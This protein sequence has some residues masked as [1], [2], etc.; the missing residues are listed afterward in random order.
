M[1]DP[2]ELIESQEKRF[3]N[4]GMVSNALELLRDLSTPADEVVSMVQQDPGTTGMILRVAN[5]ALHRRGQPVSTLRAAIVRLGN[6]Q[7]SQILLSAGLQDKNTKEDIAYYQYWEHSVNV[8]VMA[9]DL[10]IREGVTD[11]HKLE[12]IFILGLLHNLG[13]LIEIR[14]QLLGK[15][16]HC[17]QLYSLDQMAAEKKAFGFNHCELGGILC[18]YWGLPEVF[19]EACSQHHVSALPGSPFWESVGYV[20]MADAAA[21]SLGIYPVRCQHPSHSPETVPELTSERMAHLENAHTE[22][23]GPVD[24]FTRLL[25]GH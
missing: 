17:M 4:P 19:Y 20:R 7:I 9:R 24:E 11:S 2:A 8:A 3:S 22:N 10:A 1:L 15:I 5:C 12:E 18:Q 21:E 6:L 23:K 25:L 13:L 14:G 16:L